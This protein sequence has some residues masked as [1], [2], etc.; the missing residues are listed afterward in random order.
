MSED[1]KEYTV[2]LCTKEIFQYEPYTKPCKKTHNNLARDDYRSSKVLLGIE[3]EVLKTYNRIIK[4]TDSKI[5]N[6]RVR[7]V[8]HP[9]RDKLFARLQNNTDI[10]YYRLFNKLKDAVIFHPICVVCGAYMENNECKHFLH[11]VYVNLRSM[12]E[13][14]KEKIN[15]AK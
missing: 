9:S 12:A 15:N 4:N 10:R 7:I 14:L 8:R 13:E 5:A 3:D 1:C 11:Q 6:N 2:G